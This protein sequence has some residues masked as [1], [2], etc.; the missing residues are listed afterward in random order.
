MNADPAWPSDS[1]VYAD[2]GPPRESYDQYVVN[3]APGSVPLS[4]RER[5]QYPNAYAPSQSCA[6]EGSYAEP[7]A[8][9]NG[10]T[11]ES[12]LQFMDRIEREVMEHPKEPGY[13]DIEKENR[14]PPMVDYGRPGLT[15]HDLPA[16]KS[17]RNGSEQV[18]HGQFVAMARDQCGTPFGA[19]AATHWSHGY[20]QH[21][22]MTLDGGFGPRASSGSQRA[23]FWRPNYFR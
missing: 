2:T 7:Y 22:P 17:Y 14:A 6:Q 11:H 13:E 1:G 12:M 19:E 16:G 9:V 15:R 4:T 23:G 20:P 10:V 21:N 18:E 5:L 8:P 3:Q